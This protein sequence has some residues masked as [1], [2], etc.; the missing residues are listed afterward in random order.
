M[1]RA[2][3]LLEVLTLRLAFAG[4]KDAGGA[5]RHGLLPF[6]DLHRMD[7]V[8]LRDLLD[9]FDA[10]ERL[11]GHA[12]LEFGIVSS[13]FGFHLVSCGSGLLPPTSTNH[14]LAPGPN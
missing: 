6:G 3:F 10:L 14:S 7:L 13:A 4:S 9:G 12:G 8:V 2:A 5:L 1:Q 11:K